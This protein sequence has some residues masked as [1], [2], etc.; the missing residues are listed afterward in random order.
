M[1]SAGVV[2]V[3]LLCLLSACTP[4]SAQWTPG[5]II[6]D[7]VSPS[8]Q[9][10]SVTPSGSASP[11]PARPA[12]PDVAGA[13]DVSSFD[14]AHF[15]SPTGRIWCA[16]QADWTLCHFP[17]GMDMSK[18]PKSETVCPEAGLD[19]TGVSV[20]DKDVDYFCSG[21]AEALPQTDGEYTAWWQG[22]GFPS[23][24]YDGQ[25][26]ATLPYGEKLLYG[27]FVCGSEQSGV[28][29]GNVGNG[30]GFRVSRAGVTLIK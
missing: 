11:T 3:F 16:M 5:P 14:S 12:V 25:R 26:M 7:P 10:P 2:G 20:N 13:L 15:A 23:V 22:S 19:V 30:A 21:G 9:T 27:N 28:T 17:A 1:R 18:V 6:T 8:V 24:K 4:A 29:C